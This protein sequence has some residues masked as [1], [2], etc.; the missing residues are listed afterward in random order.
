MRGRCGEIEQ[1]E[2]CGIEI[3]SLPTE[4]EVEMGSGSTAGSSAERDELSAL[5]HRSFTDLELRQ[6]HV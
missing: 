5:D 6:V 2:L 1:E 3:G 4:T